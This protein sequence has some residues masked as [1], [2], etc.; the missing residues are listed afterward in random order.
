MTLVTTDKSKE[1]LKKLWSKIRDL[2]STITSNS[3]NYDEKHMEIK[4]DLDDDLLLKKTLT[5]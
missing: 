5:F 2:I 1:T 3:D 4:F